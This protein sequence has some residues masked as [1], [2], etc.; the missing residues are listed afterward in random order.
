M[1]SDKEVPSTE[2]EKASEADGVDA[3]A[4]AKQ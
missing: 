1:P 4:E 2:D 3:K